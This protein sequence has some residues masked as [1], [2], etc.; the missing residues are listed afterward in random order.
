MI[1]VRS[2]HSLSVVVPVYNEAALVAESTEQM[3]DFLR[4]SFAGFELIIVESG[5]TDGSGELCDE[6]A[7]RFSEVR[8][9]HEGA[10][11]G[12]GS[13][14]KQG[15]QASTR[16]LVTMMTLDLPFPFDSVA[17][18]AA[19]MP[20]NDAV[21]SYRSTDTRKSHFRKLQSLVFNTALRTTLRLKTRHLNSALKMYRR[22]VIQ[23]LPLTSNGWF[24]DTEIVYWLERRGARTTVI[25]VPLVDRR[26]GVSSTTLATPIHILG[27]AYRFARARSSFDTPVS[28]GVQRT[29]NK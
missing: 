5:R 15:F 17:Q 11:R 8:V 4:G 9:I 14:L 7:R 12:F 27:E 23:G 26:V 2:P 13:A 19:L 16:D 1:A 20:W 6:V 24:I 21:L 25:P 28:E 10:R 18:A 22:E 3:V 29:S